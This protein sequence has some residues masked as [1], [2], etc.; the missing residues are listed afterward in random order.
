MSYIV[1]FH[2]YFFEGLILESSIILL[3]ADNN[4]IGLVCTNQK[5]HGSGTGSFNPTPLTLNHENVKKG[6]EK[7][8][9]LE[10]KV[11]N[12]CVRGMPDHRIDRHIT[13]NSQK[14]LVAVWWQDIQESGLQWSS[15]ADGE[16]NNVAI[17]RIK[18]LP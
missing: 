9:S 13:V 6:I 2:L 17:I 11:C 3:Y 7:M 8:S 12:I 5:R 1:M 15:L 10:L 18:R 4:R 16:S 14:D